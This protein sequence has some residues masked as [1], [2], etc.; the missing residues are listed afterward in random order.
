MDSGGSYGRVSKSDSFKFSNESRITDI[1]VLEAVDKDIVADKEEVL[2]MIT[3]LNG[4]L[5]NYCSSP[6]VKILAYF[7]KQYRVEWYSDASRML[8][9]MVKENDCHIIGSA[10]PLK[11]SE[12]VHKIVLAT[13]TYLGS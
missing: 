2:D 7:S 8:E 6:I 9:K 11:F 1:I 12:I 10:D 4:Y 5:F 13:Y 3:V